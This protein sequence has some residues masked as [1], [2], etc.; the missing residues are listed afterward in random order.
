[1]N[2][3]AFFVVLIGLPIAGVVGGLVAMTYYRVLLWW[4]ES[5]PERK[6]RVE[7]VVAASFFVLAAT[8][9]GLVTP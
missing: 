3:L 2:W 9:A 6:Q 1:M 8:V 4:F 5:P 7:A